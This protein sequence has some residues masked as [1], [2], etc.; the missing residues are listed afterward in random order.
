MLAV[1]GKD[2]AVDPAVVLNGI[3]AHARNDFGA[4]LDGG[5]AQDVDQ[6]LPTMIEVE[7]VTAQ[8]ELQLF[9]G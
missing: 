9:D 8:G 2:D 5:I 6:G 4:G 3:H 7:D 1:I